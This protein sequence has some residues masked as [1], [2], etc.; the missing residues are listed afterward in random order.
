MCLC[1]GFALLGGQPTEPRAEKNA[2]AAGTCGP[3]NRHSGSSLNW[4]GAGIG[5]KSQGRVA[6]TLTFVGWKRVA[7]AKLVSLREQ[8][9]GTL[10]PRP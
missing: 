2:R 5:V 6:Q 7:R 1:N 3:D 4:D 8:F 10:V 9:E